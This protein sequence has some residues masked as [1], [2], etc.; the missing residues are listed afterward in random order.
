M[1]SRFLWFAV[2]VALGLTILMWKETR[3][4]KGPPPRTDVSVV[5]AAVGHLTGGHGCPSGFDQSTIVCEDSSGFWIN[6]SFT[7]LV[8]GESLRTDD[9]RKLWPRREDFIVLRKC[10]GASVILWKPAHVAFGVTNLKIKLMSR[11]PD[12]IIKLMCGHENEAGTA[13]HGSTAGVPRKK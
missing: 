1:K 7:C 4:Y 5:M 8:T 13:E 11:D 12:Q 9:V 3:E 2:A 6:M 10:D